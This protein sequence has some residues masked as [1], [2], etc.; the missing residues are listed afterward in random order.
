MQ[1][2]EVVTPNDVDALRGLAYEC[3]VATEFWDYSG[4]HRMVSSAALVAVLGALGVDATS[5]EAVA[6]A[7]WERDIAP[8]RLTLP[9]SVVMRAGYNYELAVHV[10]HGAGVTLRVELE[11]G[12]VRHAPQLDRYVPP[13]HVDGQLVGRATFELAPDLP[14]GW[15]EIV[16]TVEG[17]DVARAVLAVTPFRMELPAGRSWGLMSQMYSVRGEESWGVGDYVDLADFASFVGEE[18][19][20]FVLIN[21]M[22]ACQPV[23][24]LTPSPYLPVSRQFLSHLYIRPDRITEYALLSGRQR[25]RV[26]SLALAMRARNRDAAA[27]DR[28][29]AW[30]AKLEALSIIFAAGRSAGR[31]REFARFRRRGGQPL[32]DWGLWCALVEA[33]KSAEDWPTEL[34]NIEAPGISAAR[35]EHA[36]RIEFF[37]WLQWI[38]TQQL[39]QAQQVAKDAGMRLGLMADLAVGV[40]ANGADVWTMPDAFAKGIGVGAPPDMYNQ[41]GQNWNQPPWHPGELART[42]YQPLRDMA[43]T[44]LA[45]AGALRVDHIIGLFR[46]WWIPEGLGAA[47]GT[48]VRYDHE[49]MLGVLLLEAHRAGA[50]VIG[51]DLGTVEPWVRD[52][53]AD[54]GVLGTSIMWFEKDE[55]GQFLAPERYRHLALST[56]NTHDLP[57]TPGYLAGEHVELRHRLGLL[58]NTLEEARQEAR[59]EQEF[60]VETLIRRGLLSPAANHSEQDII[61]AMH[62]YVAATPSQLI[63]VALVDGV[64]EKRT[65]NQPGTDNEYPN[66]RIPLADGLGAAQLVEDLPANERLTAL[67]AIMRE[68]VR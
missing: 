40:H 5:D 31:Q 52:Y 60:M 49:A 38:A 14:L 32:E 12:G 43:R 65:Q 63:G 13:R 45:N 64:G 1:A 6:K 30:T 18:G 16:A 54:R 58:E 2:S 35:V 42:G 26:D 29:L 61:E 47:E 11:D 24:P 39:Q 66:W 37:I 9:P 22:H 34:A 20:D 3:G 51:E 7:R 10:P 25:R 19:A 17:A 44:V 56:V 33:R 27:L 41:L 68:T 4:N 53:L 21:P 62:R 48:Y 59:T 23:A 8:W 28:D 67:M 50:I 36:D 15:H 46:L 57:P 55:Y